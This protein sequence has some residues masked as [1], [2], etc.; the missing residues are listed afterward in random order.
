MCTRAHTNTPAKCFAKSRA[1]FCNCWR[2]LARRRGRICAL[3]SPPP[4][5]LGESGAIPAAVAALNGRFIKKNS[6]AFTCAPGFVSYVVANSIPS[7]QRMKDC[8]RGHTT[9]KFSPRRAKTNELVSTF[10]IFFAS[11]RLQL[12]YF[13]VHFYILMNYGQFCLVVLK[14]L[15]NVTFSNCSSI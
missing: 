8:A 1:H 3:G 13:Y 14:M 7:R 11:K 5:L 12:H 9:A 15:L 2:N 4:L 6:P 10:G